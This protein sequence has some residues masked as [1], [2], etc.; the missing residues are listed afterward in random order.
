[1]DNLNSILIDPM[2]LQGEDASRMHCLKLLLTGHSNN[3]IAQELNF[4]VKNIE[5]I[6][7]KF[8]RKAQIV[9]QGVN[10]S[11]INPRVRL[12]LHGLENNWLQFDVNPTEFT[13]KLSLTNNQYSTLVLC[14]LGLSNIGISDFLYVSRKTTESRLNSLFTLFG[15]NTVNNKLINP[16]FTLIN[17]AVF[18]GIVNQEHLIE[19][20][21]SFDI[22]EWESLKTNREQIINN[23]NSYYLNKSLNM[24]NTMNMSDILQKVQILNQEQNVYNFNQ[25]DNHN[26]NYN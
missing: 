5:A 10:R 9:K 3:S 18:R 25:I 7:A 20:A 2:F 12:M 16:R 1:M 26:G 11:I 14:A 15:V 17:K 24:N 13:T 19:I 4:S 21:K 6:I 8:M 22:G 23:I